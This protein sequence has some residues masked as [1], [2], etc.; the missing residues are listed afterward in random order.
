MPAKDALRLRDELGTVLRFA[1]GRRGDDFGPFRL[2][3][4]DQRAKASE[5][6]QRARDAVGGKLAGRGD[7]AAEPAQ[8]LFV[9][10]GGRRPRGTVINDE[11]HRVRADVDDGDGS[12]IVA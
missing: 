11:P 3:L 1:R 4:I 12:P 5:L 6:A 7:G 8:H 2:E 10:D 9:I